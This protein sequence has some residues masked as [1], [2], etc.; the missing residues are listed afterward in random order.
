MLRRVNTSLVRHRSV[1]AERRPAMG[2]PGLPRPDRL[3]LQ[4]SVRPGE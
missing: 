4:D 3:A 2:R 1:V